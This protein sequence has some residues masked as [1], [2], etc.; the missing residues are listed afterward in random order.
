[1]SPMQEIAY[2]TFGK[3]ALVAGLICHVVAILFGMMSA[4]GADAFFKIIYPSSW[5]LL[6]SGAYAELRHRGGRPMNTWRFYLIFMAAVFPVLGPPVV[7]GLIYSF[8]RDGQEA[9]GN[10]SGL[11]P[12]MLKLRAS[13]W[14]ILVLVF[15]LFLVMAI[16]HSKNDPYFRRRV[17]KS[18]PP[19][20]VLSTVQQETAPWTVI[21]IKGK[22]SC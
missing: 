8:P 20:S 19:Q 14:I 5:M 21:R 12:A 6:T 4:S 11:F 1:M 7:L 17:P 16:L 13:G 18:R 15:L 3:N 2:T 9:Q 10:L 22:E